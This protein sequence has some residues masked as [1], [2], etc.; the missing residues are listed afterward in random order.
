VWEDCSLANGHLKYFFRMPYPIDM[1]LSF[2]SEN[3]KTKTAEFFLE[4]EP[5][6]F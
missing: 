3:L 6:K 2:Y 5:L 1:G 4:R